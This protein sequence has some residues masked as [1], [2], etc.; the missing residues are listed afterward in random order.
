MDQGNA[1]QF[2]ETLENM[3]NLMKHD[4]RKLENEH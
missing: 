1:K 4:M 3:T 2:R